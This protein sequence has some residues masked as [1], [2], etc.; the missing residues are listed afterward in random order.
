MKWQ[1]WRINQSFL[2]SLYEHF[3]SNTFTNKDAYKVYVEHH[4][5]N[6]Y[7]DDVWMQMNVRSHLCAAAYRKIIKRVGRGEYQIPEDFATRLSKCKPLKMRINFTTVS[8]H[9]CKFYWRLQGP[10]AQ[11]TIVEDPREKAPVE[12]YSLNLRTRR[13]LIRKVSRRLYHMVLPLMV[14]GV[15]TKRPTQ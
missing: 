2:K 10:V 9:R 3:G 11:L 15:L 7:I 4:S 8:V 1:T 6:T 14:A 12:L 13:D 5:P